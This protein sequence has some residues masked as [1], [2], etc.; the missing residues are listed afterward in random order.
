MK[1]HLNNVNRALENTIR[2]GI[3]ALLMVN[4]SMDFISLKKMLGTTDG[5]LSSNL[6][7]LL[8]HKYISVKKK[9]IGNKPN[10]SYAALEAGKKAFRL[11]IDAMEQIIAQGKNA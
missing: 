11:H 1:E 5:N 9:F 4:Q 6:S 7:Y 10:T 8:Q 2:L 3:M